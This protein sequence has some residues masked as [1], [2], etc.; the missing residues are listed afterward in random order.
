MP[1]MG[2]DQAA[3]KIRAINPNMKIIFATG[4]DKNT[5]D[6]LAGEMVV[7]KPFSIVELSHLIRQQLDS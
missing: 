2:G 6:H 7:G 1:L 3:G 5:Q 4:Y